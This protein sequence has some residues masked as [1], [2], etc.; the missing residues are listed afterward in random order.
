MKISVYTK[1][2]NGIPNLEYINESAPSKGLLFVQ[3]GYT[4][5]KEEGAEWLAM[6]FV[7]EE[8]HVVCVDAY[9]HGARIEEPFLTKP[10]N[11]KVISLF[12]IV[13]QTAKD[14]ITLF[15]GK[16]TTYN[17][18]DYIGIS[19]GGMI[20]FMLVTFT[21][22]VSKVAPVIGAPYHLKLVWW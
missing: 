4:S 7:R 13:P 22:K 18:F 20:G 6:K 1:E 14:I 17:H 16:F 3:H 8:F 11:E 12:E 5:S 10:E 9:K 21:D 19:M 2:Y 15:E